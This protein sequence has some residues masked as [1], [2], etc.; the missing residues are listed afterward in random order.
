MF[1]NVHVGINT[2]SSNTA[3]AS[4]FENIRGIEKVRD[5]RIWLE[6]IRDQ[7]LENIMYMFSILIRVPG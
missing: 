2:N 6:N 3:K 1:W 4:D 5:H 7:T